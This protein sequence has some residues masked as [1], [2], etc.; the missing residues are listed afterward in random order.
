MTT[1]E[2]QK[3]VREQATLIYTLNQEGQSIRKAHVAPVSGNNKEQT[4]FETEVPHS[5]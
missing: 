1:E 5:N 3:T 4:R 2:P